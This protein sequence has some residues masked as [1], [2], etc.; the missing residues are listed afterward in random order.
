[1]ATTKSPTLS[2]SESEN[3]I[4]CKFS[5]G[6]FIIAISEAGSAPTN[7]ALNSLPSWSLTFISF[8]FAIT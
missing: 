1:M 8:A 6:I 7:T 5:G 2:F 3:F 4:D